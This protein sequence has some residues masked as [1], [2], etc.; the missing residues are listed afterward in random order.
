MLRPLSP[1]KEILVRCG[2]EPQNRSVRFPN[3]KHGE[4]FFSTLVDRKI[5]KQDV[6]VEAMFV[7]RNF[8][9]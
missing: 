6:Y 5:I 3:C 4:I 8:E 9:F 1:D 2:Y 7:S